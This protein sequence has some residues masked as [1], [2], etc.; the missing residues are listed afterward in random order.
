VR[1]LQ[2]GGNGYRD[3][4]ASHGSNLATTVDI[5]GSTPVLTETAPMGFGRHWPSATVLL[6]GR[7]AVTGGTQY[8]NNGGADAVYAAELWNPASGA[9]TLAASAAQIRVYHS[10]AILMPD[11]AVLSTGGGAPG[12]VNN[13][14]A[15]LYFPP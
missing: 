15:E 5:N 11:G 9:W 12:P 7:V 10:A 13:L 3:G 6:D 4:Y 14:N 1:I 2:V 8:A